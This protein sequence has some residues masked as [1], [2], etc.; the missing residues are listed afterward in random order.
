MP[1]S[2]AAPMPMAIAHPLEAET[3]SVTLLIMWTLLCSSY[4]STWRLL[5]QDGDADAD[6]VEVAEVLARRGAGQERH[7]VD[8]VPPHV[9]VV[10]VRPVA[11]RMWIVPVVLRRGRIVGAPLCLA[12][13]GATRDLER[14]RLWDSD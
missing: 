8:E 12:V 11:E 13:E 9:T 4:S 3:R 7:I 10:L 2:T 14:G 5:G 6:L 1:A